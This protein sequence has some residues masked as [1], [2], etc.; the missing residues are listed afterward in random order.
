VNGGLV[1]WV[2]AVGNCWSGPLSREAGCGR[3]GGAVMPGDLGVG[4]SDVGLGVGRIDF[5]V[6]SCS[7]CERCERMEGL[8]NES[9]FVS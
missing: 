7:I 2:A 4:S 9:R 5:D 1:I 6:L 8:L 3:R